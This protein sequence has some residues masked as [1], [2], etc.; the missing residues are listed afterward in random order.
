[1]NTRIKTKVQ[2]QC[3]IFCVYFANAN[4]HFCFV[5]EHTIKVLFLVICKFNFRLELAELA[6]INFVK[7]SFWIIL[8]AIITLIIIWDFEIVIWFNIVIIIELIFLLGLDP[9]KAP[10]IRPCC[11]SRK[12]L[13]S[14]TF[15]GLGDACNICGKGWGTYLS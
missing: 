9:L 14:T 2:Y 6:A 12:F 3:L 8:I 10:N 11:G 13:L 4:L 15:F 5:R 7:V 1:M